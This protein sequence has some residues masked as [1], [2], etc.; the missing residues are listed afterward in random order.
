MSLK[1]SRIKIDL[2]K[3]RKWFFSLK[4][5]PDYRSWKDGSGKL[6]LKKGSKFFGWSV[7]T[8]PDNR[9]GVNTFAIRKNYL[10]IV[11][12][13][14][15][16][17]SSICYGY[18]EEILNQFPQAFRAVLIGLYPNFEYLPHKDC[19]ENSFR[20][21]IAIETNPKSAFQVAGKCIHI[22]ADGFI[23]ILN[24]N[25]IHSAWNFGDSPRIHLTWQMPMKNFK[26]YLT[27]KKDFSI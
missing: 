22:P 7:F 19:P 1:R 11:N 25:E 21:H 16:N 17:K 5:T 6:Y 12:T 18:C 10:N 13:D 2:K 3:L 8:H 24:T 15:K 23:W 26:D 9:P 4:E 20:M 14:F 27:L